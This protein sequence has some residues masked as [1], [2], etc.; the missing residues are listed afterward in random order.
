MHQGICKLSII[1]IRAQPNSRSE[2]V[3]QLLFGERY[4]VL[5]QVDEWIKIE[6]ISEN[7]SGWIS[8]NQFDEYLSPDNEMHVVN[9]F[10]M[11]TAV[12]QSTNTHTYL[13]PGSVIHRFEPSSNGAA[14]YINHDKYVAQIELRD[15]G[16]IAISELEAYALQFLNCPYLWGGKTMWGIDCSGFTQII[17]KVM[18]IQIPRD[19]SQQAELGE[20]V[21]F[22]NEAK[23]GDL[24][25]FEN[26]SGKISHVGLMLKPGEILHA[27]GRVRLDVLDSYGIYDSN[28]CKHTH[29]LRF[30]KRFL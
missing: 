5:E 16:H 8:H 3:S 19:A 27:S 14:F 28:L 23:I 24:A 9:R 30:I 17:F 1:P 20:I 29:P 4:S 18:G 15:I 6:T 11:I 21:N 7:Y 12:N 13:L 10:P 22:V 26:E 25:F 2:L